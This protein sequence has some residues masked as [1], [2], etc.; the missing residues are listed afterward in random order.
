M[1]ARL[2]VSAVCFA[3]VVACGQ[4]LQAAEQSYSSWKYE[5]PNKRYVSK[6]EFS[7]GGAYGHSKHHLVVYYPQEG[8]NQ[9]YYFYNPESK[10]YWG[11]C[12]S[13]HHPSYQK[14]QMHWCYLKGKSKWG[15]LTEECP[16]IPGSSNGPEI[17]SPPLPPGF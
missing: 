9:W 12:A 5:T 15:E 1:P 7:T 11:R 17:E 16:P 2:V 8:K 6:Y 4:A 13:P 3:I 14:S 10:N